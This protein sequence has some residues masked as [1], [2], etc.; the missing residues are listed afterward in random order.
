MF[1]NYRTTINATKRLNKKEAVHDLQ[2][3]R[4]RIRQTVTNKKT[5]MTDTL[6]KL[7]LTQ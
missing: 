6:F 3:V 1:K 4:R 7:I 2:F 5:F